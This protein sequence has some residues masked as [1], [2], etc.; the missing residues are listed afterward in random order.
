MI[1]SW[2]TFPQDWPE[3][4]P[5][6]GAEGVW[7]FNVKAQDAWEESPFEYVDLIDTGNDKVV[8]DLRREAR[9]KAS[10]A[11]VAWS[12]WLVTTFRNGRLFRMEWFADRAEAL[13]AVRLRE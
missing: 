7:D 3:S 9:G 4:H 10:G 2:K 5:I 13:E 11:S 1:Q 6:Q 8:M 12:Y